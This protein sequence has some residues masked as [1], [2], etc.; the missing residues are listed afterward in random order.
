MTCMR[1][2]GRLGLRGTDVRGGWGL[3]VG[4]RSSVEVGGWMGRGSARTGALG[5]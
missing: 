1:G 5:L 2:E 3:D 4:T